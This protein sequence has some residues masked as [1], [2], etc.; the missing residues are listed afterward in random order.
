MSESG[1]T[2]Y[3]PA[4]V[5]DTTTDS[6]EASTD[7]RDLFSS[8]GD[9]KSNPGIM[10]T[11]F[12]YYLQTYLPLLT[13]MILI[14]PFVEILY[15]FLQNYFVPNTI[16]NA[17]ANANANHS[18]Y[19]DLDNEIIKNKIIYVTNLKKRIK[20]S[21]SLP[22]EDQFYNISGHFCDPMRKDPKEDVDNMENSE[23]S[24]EIRC[25][26][27]HSN[28]NGVPHKNQN[29]IDEVSTTPIC[30]MS[31]SNK[32]KYYYK[33]KINDN[34]VTVV[35]CQCSEGY[36]LNTDSNNTPH[37]CEPTVCMQAIMDEFSKGTIS[38]N[39]CYTKLKSDTISNSCTSDIDKRL[40]DNFCCST[41][42][43][44]SKTNMSSLGTYKD[45]L[46][47]S[48]NGSWSAKSLD[49]MIDD[50]TIDGTGVTINDKYSLFTTDVIENKYDLN[51]RFPLYFNKYYGD[52]ESS[53]IDQNIQNMYSDISD[54]DGTINKLVENEISSDM[55]LINPPFTSSEKNSD[56][57]DDT[58]MDTIYSKNYPY[59]A[60]YTSSCPITL[61][62]SNKD[63]DN[64]KY[65]S[66]KLVYSPCANSAFV[67]ENF[68][69]DTENNYSMDDFDGLPYIN[70]I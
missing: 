8:D 32:H 64:V 47:D 41:F 4:F 58:N 68:Y 26:N 21:G 40:V 49:D 3:N 37:T 60:S 52:E 48:A 12:K 18:D 62:K 19:I 45:V 39:N 59:I 61:M 7:G 50:T 43:N 9:S 42:L 10:G 44:R 20:K 27:S 46:Y 14:I 22:D 25:Y 51:C 70:L 35:G 31:P 5:D 30:E 66:N 65:V 33:K 28:Y 16:S 29:F 24:P 67:D 1:E 2:T 63:I 53:E 15:G 54:N 69:T 36:E 6:V 17:N 55:I 13:I 57:D 38:A 34:D 11:S 56:T 23:P